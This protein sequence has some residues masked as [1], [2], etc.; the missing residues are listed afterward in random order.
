MSS[1]S[2][3]PVDSLYIVE[4]SASL[5]E[6]DWG[7]RFGHSFSAEAGASSPLQSSQ[8]FSVDSP[9]WLS[10]PSALSSAS[11]ICRLAPQAREVEATTER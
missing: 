8:R 9:S 5:P 11:G 6:S 10:A 4:A 1:N 2:D 7:R 3:F